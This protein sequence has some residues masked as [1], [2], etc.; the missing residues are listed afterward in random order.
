MKKLVFGIALAAAMAS[1]VLSAQAGT[2]WAW[3]QVSAGPQHT[4]AIRADG[5][6]WAWGNNGY[7][8]IGDGTITTHDP[9]GTVNNNRHTPIQIG[10]DANWAYVSAGVAH[11]VAVRTDGT[12]W[13]WG[14]NLHGALGDGTNN[15]YAPVPTRI[16]M[17]YDWALVAAGL[18]HTT[19]VRSDGSLWAWGSDYYRRLCDD[20]TADRHAPVRIGPG[21]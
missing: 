7:G 20:A 16:G 13:A 10:T 8:R 18:N 11:T 17:D 2:E 14:S 1:T 3:K 9:R 6:L 4:A 5:T 19:A 21:P 12:L 15:R